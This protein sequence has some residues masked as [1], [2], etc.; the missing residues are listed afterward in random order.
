[1]AVHPIEYRYSYPQMRAVWEEE[2]RLRQLLRVE[3]VL[4]EALAELGRIPAQAAKEIAASA[5][6]VTLAQVKAIEAKTDHEMMALARALDEQS[7]ESG[8]YVHLGATSEDI[9]A[10]G[11]ALQLRDAHRILS[12]DLTALERALVTL[13]EKHKAT[14]MAGRTHGQHAIPITFGYKVARWADEVRRHQERMGTLRPRLLL[15]K[16][17]G[18][19]GNYASFGDDE[20]EKIV[21][22]KLG[23]GTARITSQIIDRDG[24][25]EFLFTQA[26]IAATVDKICREIRNLARSEIKEVE[27]PFTSE[28]VGSST[29][30][31][32]RNPLKSERLCGLARVVKANVIPAL[33]NITIEHERD[34]SHDPADLVILPESCVLTDY[35]LRQLTL[36]VSDLRVYPARM[37]RNLELSG[38]LLAS[39]RLMLALTDA[40]MGRQEAHELVRQA[41]WEAVDTGRDFREALQER[42]VDQWLDEAAVE[43]A[44]DFD[45]H[46]GLCISITERV[47]RDLTAGD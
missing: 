26:L 27:E 20:V 47:V 34:I 8:G 14:V 6:R 17:S 25:A 10:T 9:R 11:L 24:I 42:G 46:L 5:E 1:M 36:I 3:V 33:E 43:R 18:A 32:K 23:L 37:R 16:M 15:G 30:P 35:L 12:D 4:G 13:A 45:Q 40:G 22:G 7:G 2:H 21:M 41:A 44:L 28:Q 31:Q 39:E 19:V 29:M 38:T